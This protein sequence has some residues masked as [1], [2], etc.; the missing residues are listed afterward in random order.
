MKDRI[1]NI[2][3]LLA[4]AAAL[5][6]TWARGAQEEAALPLAASPAATAAPPPAEV[7]RARRRETRALEQALLTTLAESEHTAPE[8]KALAEQQL[9]GMARNDEMELAVEGALAAHGFSDALCV[10]RD[11]SMTVFLPIEI[12][13]DEAA[14][15]LEIARDISGLEAENI[16]LTGY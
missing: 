9:A 16:R 11:G 13:A 7:Y 8:T 12:S 3:M 6:L 4:V 10:S 15:F 5:I 1:L 14:F 2:L